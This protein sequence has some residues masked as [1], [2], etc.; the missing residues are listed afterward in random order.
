[1]S[2]EVFTAFYIDNT[3]HN[4]NKIKCMK[5]FDSE[6]RA[7]KEVGDYLFL[8]YGQMDVIIDELKSWEPKIL[9]I[10]EENIEGFV[11][12]WKRYGKKFTHTHFSCLFLR[13]LTY[14]KPVI[15]YYKKE[16]DSDGD[17]DH[18]YGVRRS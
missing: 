11:E 15:E 14:S 7:R 17:Q 8:N 13:K 1:M 10:L 3:K 18:F 4:E 9:P 6:F 5:V 12:F 2:R 16:N